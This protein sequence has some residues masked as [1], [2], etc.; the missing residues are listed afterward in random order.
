M[1]ESV[2]CYLRLVVESTGARVPVG[3]IGAGCPQSTATGCDLS[4][5]SRLAENGVTP[6]V[7]F[8]HVRVTMNLPTNKSLVPAGS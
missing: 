7:G 4:L 6:V 8:F 2:P 1:R 3:D 5:G